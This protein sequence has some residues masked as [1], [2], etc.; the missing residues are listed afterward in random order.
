MKNPNITGEDLAP[1]SDESSPGWRYE[2]EEFM[3]VEYP[4]CENA[5]SDN[6]GHQT[7]LPMS[8]VVRR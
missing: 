8:P 4:S 2:T 5:I 7:S 1:V 6:D 3:G